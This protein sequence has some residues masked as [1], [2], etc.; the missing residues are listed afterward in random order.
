MLRLK[1]IA[2]A[3]SVLPRTIVDGGTDPRHRKIDALPDEMLDRIYGP[4]FEL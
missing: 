1:P 4:V 2:V 3:Q